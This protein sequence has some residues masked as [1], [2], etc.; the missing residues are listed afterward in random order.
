MKDNC[1]DIRK[2][3]IKLGRPDLSNQNKNQKAGNFQKKGLINLWHSTKGKTW[4]Q[5]Q[6]VQTRLFGQKDE[7]Y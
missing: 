1:S 6:L 3:K 5:I 4:K 7:N 2:G